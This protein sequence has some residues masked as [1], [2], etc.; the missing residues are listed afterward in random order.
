[1]RKG[2]LLPVLILLSVVFVFS[3]VWKGKGRLTGQVLDE[4]GNPLPGVK[5]KLTYIRHEGQVETVTDAQGR[6]TASWLRNGQWHVDFEKAGFEPRKV[7]VEV[8]EVTKNPEVNIPLKK[9]EGI[10]LTEELKNA[11]NEGNALFDQG[12]YEEAI[13][14]YS[15]ILED[16]PDAYVIHK[17]VGNSYFQMEKYEE[18]EKSY[19]KVLEKDPR[20]SEAM[21][22]IGNCYANRGD[23]EKALEW[24]AKIEFEKISDPTVLYNIGTNFYNLSMFAE[25]LKYYKR[26]V[27]AKGDFLDGLYQLGLVYLNLM[28]TEEAIAAFESYLQHDR[29]SAR[30]AQVR[31][32]LEYLR[33]RIA[34][35]E[36]I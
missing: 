17:N 34:E 28:N 18:A 36:G 1:M 24:Y 31:S 32:F 7:S 30:A 15:R 23:N 26:A 35:K 25:A 14:V 16:Y 20:N 5:V 6:W 9:L 33:R 29:D 2:M 4:Q 8:S 19:Q 10:V 13:A 3:Q 27:E 21:M 12:N 22:L 11:L